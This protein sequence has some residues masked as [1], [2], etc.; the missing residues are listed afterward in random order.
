MTLTKKDIVS[1]ISEET[2][3]KQIWVKKIVQ[4]T[5]DSILGALVKGDRV[6][7]R[8][9]GIFK[10]KSRRAR[11]GRNPRTGVAV[12]VPPK[13]AVVFKAGMEMKKKVA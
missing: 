7:L 12:S 3:I 4:K 5:F 6:E 1:K 13:R 8:D 9:F 11:K 2:K 10:V